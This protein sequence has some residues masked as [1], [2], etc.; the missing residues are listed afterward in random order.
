MGIVSDEDFDKEF[1]NS[2]LPSTP[3]TVEPLIPEVVDMPTPGR[4][5]GDVN[6]PSSLRKIIGET[7]E[8]EG[9]QAALALAADFGISESSV[10]AYA[11]GTTSTATYDTPNKEIM[12]HIKERKTKVVKSALHKITTAMRALSPEKIE[13][14]SAKEIS[15]IAKDMASVVKMIDNTSSDSSSQVTQPRFVVFAPQIKNESYFGDVI[16]AKE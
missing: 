9:R 6:V 12:T 2:G 13:M 1:N 5:K 8:L 10:S 14:S 3:I 16:Q 11:H 7:S 4:N 15:S